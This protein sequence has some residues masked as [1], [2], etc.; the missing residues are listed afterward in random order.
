MKRL[1]SAVAGSPNGVSRHPCSRAPT[2]PIRS[3][4]ASALLAALFVLTGC[5]GGSA[6]DGATAA[7]SASD[8]PKIP[9]T[10][11]S[12]GTSIDFHGAAWDGNVCVTVGDV[13]GA[14]S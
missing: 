1:A 14:A 4:C 10:S 8:A 11:H 9:V 12:S 7:A 5:G 13:G 3:A 2:S 6:G